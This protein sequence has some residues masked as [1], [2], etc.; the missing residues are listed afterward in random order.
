MKV[1]VEDIS[2]KNNDHK[3]DILTLHFIGYYPKPVGISEKL[4]EKCLV[5]FNEHRGQYE[6]EKDA[7]LCVLNKGNL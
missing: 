6:W 4:Y 7:I 5:A 1:N 3:A 2:S